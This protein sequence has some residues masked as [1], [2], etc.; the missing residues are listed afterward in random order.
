MGPQAEGSL[1]TSALVSPTNSSGWSLF[2]SSPSSSSSAVQPATFKD[3][4]TGEGWQMAG[5][6]RWLAGLRGMYE[7]R[8]NRMCTILD[9]GSSLVSTS[10][11]YRTSA[12]SGDWDVIKTTKLFSYSWPEGGMFIWLRMHFES[13]PLWQHP[14]F[15]A[16]A[17]GDMKGGEGGDEKTK[18]IDGPMLSLALMLFLTLK[19]HLVLVSSGGMFS[20]TPEI[21]KEIGWQY[22]RLCFAAVSEEDVDEGAKRFVDGVRAFWKITDARVIEKLVDLD[23]A[24]ADGLMSV[25][26]QAGQREG[27]NNL[28]GWLGC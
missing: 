7:R 19:P 8:M 22:F 25:M 23:A 6:I 27:M 18:V 21:G 2:R 26:G 16:A 13:H 4:P 14:L 15:F 9:S 24:G 17:K 28:G 1:S 5:W 11:R 10:G 20:A 3:T 12:T